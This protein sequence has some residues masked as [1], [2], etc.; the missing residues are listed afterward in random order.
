MVVIMDELL[1]NCA[2]S[3]IPLRNQEYYHL[4]MRE[5]S[6]ASGWLYCVLESHTQ[7]DEKERHM[8]WDHLHSETFSSLDRARMRYTER[9]LCLE[10]RGFVYSDMDL[11]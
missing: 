9:R 1:Y 11:F 5:F 8:T 10:Q 2:D 6:G 3:K 4:R 7:W